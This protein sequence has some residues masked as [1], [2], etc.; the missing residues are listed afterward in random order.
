MVLFWRAGL[1]GASPE[2]VLCLEVLREVLRE[3]IKG[4]SPRGREGMFWEMLVGAVVEELAKTRGL[5]VDKVAGGPIKD[6]RYSLAEGSSVKAQGGPE[7]GGGQFE[8]VR[9]GVGKASRS[10]EACFGEDSRHK[11]G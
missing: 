9:R 11:A 3:G 5:G 6:R 7:G 2:E 10:C 1:K 8:G 4:A